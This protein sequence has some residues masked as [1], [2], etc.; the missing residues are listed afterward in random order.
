MHFMFTSSGGVMLHGIYRFKLDGRYS[1]PE[2]Y[3]LILFQFGFSYD[4]L[5]QQE[6]ELHS[7]ELC[8]GRIHCC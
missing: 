1:G 4:L 5:V 7:P 3:F 2:E 6:A 8:S